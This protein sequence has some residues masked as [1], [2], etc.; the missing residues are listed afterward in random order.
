MAKSIIAV[1]VI[2][3]VIVTASSASFI[4][5]KRMVESYTERIEQAQKNPDA[6]LL[7]EITQN[8]DSDKNKLMFI[9]NHRDIES[10]STGLIRACEEA[11]AG[12]ADMA[13]TELAV[14]KFLL[15]ELEEREKFSFE[16]I[17]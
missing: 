16:N 3:V 9:M 17:F 1:A 11:S 6:Q 10:V 13:V 8:W 14:A 7:K 15:S 5:T 2:A 4:Y 12:R